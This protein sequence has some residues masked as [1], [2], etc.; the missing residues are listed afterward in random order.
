MTGAALLIPLRYK[1]TNQ[2]KRIPTPK[3]VKTIYFALLKS[4]G[5]IY[6]SL[7]AL[8][9]IVYEYTPKN[10]LKALLFRIRLK[11]VLNEGK[12]WGKSIKKI[13]AFQKRYFND[14]NKDNDLA[15]IWLCDAQIE[16]NEKGAAE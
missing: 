13:N 9:M 6:G 1:N 15:T 5:H 3:E 7:T 11:A 8:E 10:K 14:P 12:A 16:W 2:M 4:G